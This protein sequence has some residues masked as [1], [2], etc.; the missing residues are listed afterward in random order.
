MTSFRQ[1]YIDG[2]YEQAVKDGYDLVQLKYDGH[3]CRCVSV[4][5]CQ[6]YYSDTDREFPNTDT[7]HQELPDGTYIGE[8]MRGTQWS[9][10][11][12]RHG[13]FFVFDLWEAP[14]VVIHGLTYRSR[15]AYLRQL[16]RF[17]PEHWRLVDNYRIAERN[18]L[19]S[20][21]VEKYG[22]EGLIYRR[23]SGLLDDTLIREKRV[24][25]LDGRVIGF[26]PGEGKHDGR[27]GTVFVRLPSGI[28]AAVGNG[29]DDKTRQEMQ[30]NP[31][32]FLGRVMEFSANAVFESGNV[33]HG[34]FVR[35]RE[36][37]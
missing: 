22:Y 17:F 4:D 6:T 2:T 13:K 9:K 30:D 25:T 10:R 16:A 21:F 27:V 33:R 8:Y 3:W 18:V 26:G 19:W 35:W 15:L 34:R 32:A 29:W 28:E 37:R 31:S 23:L 24:F 7:V 5:G 1:K 11:E 20:S 12:D 36:D 14:E